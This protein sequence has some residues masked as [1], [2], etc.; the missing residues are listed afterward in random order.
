M[1]SQKDPTLRKSGIGN[2]F[3][4]NLQ[5]DITHKDLH[6]TFSVFG[7]ILS[8]KVALDEKGESKGFG[9]VHF[10]SSEAADKAISK[11]NGMILGEADDDKIFVGRFVP[12]RERQK[13]MENTWTN[14]FV[15]NLPVK[16]LDESEFKALFSKCGTVNSFFVR[17]PNTPNPK[18]IETKTVFG[19]VNFETHEMAV[20]AVETY[21]EKELDGL[22]ITACR[23]IKKKEREEELKRK[24]QLNK[25]EKIKQYEGLNLYV[26]NL[27]DDVDDEKLRAIFSQYGNIQ[28]VKVAERNG[29][30]LGFG[31]VC[32]TTPEEATKAIN[33]L[34]GHP[35]QGNRKPLYV[36]L[37]E[38]R[39]VRN[40]K[41]FNMM[42]VKRNVLPFPPY[43]YPQMMP[44][45]PRGYPPQYNMRQTGPRSNPKQPMKGQQPRQTPKGPGVADPVAV[46]GMKLF[47][48]LLELTQNNRDVTGKVTGMI[49]NAHKDNL[50][51][52][53]KLVQS[54]EALKSTLDEALRTLEKNQPKA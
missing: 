24:Q 4:K 36:G 39:E 32:F 35:V 14:V 11:M 18:G 12:K 16:Y 5:K 17:E 25:M 29:V 20:K 44:M 8:C 52:C 38:P 47:E 1:W 19:F 50:A 53:E 48:K 9:F 54:K 23:A 22:V 34:N 46:M 31:Y 40:G 33:A 10:E 7:N 15:K 26:K 45:M 2:I 37:H 51:E 27:D 43:A 41:I 13:Q 30:R 28:S 49:L 6:D 42:R 3:I 21:N